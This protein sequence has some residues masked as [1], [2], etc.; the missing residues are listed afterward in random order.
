MCGR[1]YADREFIPKLNILFAEEAIETDDSYLDQYGSCNV[2]PKNG[3]DFAP[4]DEGVV[5]CQENGTLK[6]SMM[7]WGFTDRYHDGLVI[8]ARSETA[9][10]KMM[11]RDSVQRRRCVLPA[12]GFYE[13]D[14]SK[15]KYTF[16]ND[17]DG[18][19]FL[20]GIYREE[21]GEN[22]YTILTTD[23]NDS[24]KP[25][26]PRMPVMIERSKL[27]AWLEDDS[28]YRDIMQEK[29]REL[30]RNIESGQIEM[31]LGLMV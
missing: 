24:M 21:D 1:Y 4:C 31:D 6:A 16:K 12:S 20:A 30:T 19:I 7:K 2:P 28:A 27:R 26:H 29:Q 5:I 13:W 17:D 8:N 10:E 9:G 23:A 11:F 14:A 15:S 3:W 18:L 25:V 22:R